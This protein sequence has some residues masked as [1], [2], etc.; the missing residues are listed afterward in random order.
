MRFWAITA[1]IVLFILISMFAFANTKNGN[2]KIA[3]LY[4]R[5]GV[6]AASE[7]PVA[8][9]LKATIEEINKNGGIKNRKIE[10][11]EYDGRSDSGE[12]EKAAKEAIDKGAIAL[13]G[14]WT[15]TSRKAVKKVV[16]EEK[17][18]L[19]YPVQYE[20]ME[21]S[22]NIVYLGLSANQQINPTLNFIQ[23]HFGNNIYLIGSDYIYPKVAN[24]YIKELAK[25]TDLNIVGERYFKMDNK[26]F[27]AVVEDIK[28]KKPDAV[29]NTINGESNG[30]LFK[31]LKKHSITSNDIPVFSLSLDESLSEKISKEFG[32]DTLIGH[33]A[34]CSY[35][36]TM[37]KNKYNDL[38]NLVNKKLNNK[39]ITD[40]MFSI[41]LGV[42]L[43]R[44][45]LSKSDEITT[46][47]L[48]KNIKRAST[49]ISDNIYYIDPQNG[50]THKKA[51][52]AKI[53]KNSEFNTV[54]ESGRIIAPKPY[55][56][57]HAEAFWDKALGDV[58]KNYGGSWEA[59]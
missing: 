13:F 44:D 26:D 48:L 21:S 45:A 38:T 57:F 37:R 12:F 3:L 58:Y 42:V 54:W 19:F 15:S 51:Y 43:F 34:T 52:I 6:M 7:I 5:T 24:F 36:D 27:K 50:H 33:Y 18:I 35:F 1:G 31:E 22:P 47:A 17:S 8:S 40:A 39:K 32:E 28:S 23:S 9:M 16:E 11:I 55:P 10:I 46:Q 14:C 53:S 56:D 25:L 41:Y 29:I 2:I 30:E 59:K 4:S 49:N 20:G